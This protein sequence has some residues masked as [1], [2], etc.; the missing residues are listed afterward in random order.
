MY[1]HLKF[2]TAFWFILWLFVIIWYIYF[3][4]FGMLHLEKSGNPDS[5]LSDEGGCDTKRN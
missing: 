4:H 1:V 3:T 5:T 2:S